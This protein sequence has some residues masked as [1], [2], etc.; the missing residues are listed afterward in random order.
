M[1]KNTEEQISEIPAI[2]PITTQV[3]ATPGVDEMGKA[4]RK[5]IEHR[6]RRKRQVSIMGAKQ[7]ITFSLRKRYIERARI[8]A[9]YMGISMSTYIERCINKDN[10]RY[11]RILGI[12]GQEIKRHDEISGRLNDVARNA[13]LTEKQNTTGI[14]DEVLQAAISAIKPEDSYDEDIDSDFDEE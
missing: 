12:L 6:N 1:G 13:I 7:S 4:L 9:E 14:E 8:T 5:V 2:G 11:Q 10:Q 3:S